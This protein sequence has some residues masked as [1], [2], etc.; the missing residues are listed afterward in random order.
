MKKKV[1]ADG[2]RSN[3]TSHCQKIVRR[4]YSFRSKSKLQG[5][6]AA[7]HPTVGGGVDGGDAR[8]AEIHEGRKR[9]AAAEAIHSAKRAKLS[10]TFR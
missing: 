10:H 5:S 6:P 3:L 7:E 1:S 2:I 8:A 9:A 4:R